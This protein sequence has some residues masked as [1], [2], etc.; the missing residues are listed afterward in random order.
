MDNSPLGSGSK[1]EGVYK[2]ERELREA[3]CTGICQHVDCRGRKNS[4]ASSSATGKFEAS[5]GYL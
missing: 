3:E 5:L 2:S 4:S 1:E